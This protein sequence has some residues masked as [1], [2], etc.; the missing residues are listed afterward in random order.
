MPFGTAFRR[1]Q[2]DPD[3]PQLRHREEAVQAKTA[4]SSA[5]PAPSKAWPARGPTTPP[6]TATLIPLLTLGIPTQHHGHPAGAFQNYGIQP[7]R[8]CSTRPA[9]LVWALIASLYIGNVMLLVLNLPLVGPVGQAAED[10]AAAVCGIPIFCH[11]GRLWHAPERVRPGAAATRIG[12][13]GVL[14]RRFDF[15]TAPVVVGMIL[16]PLAEGADATRCRSARAASWCSAAARCRSAAG[17]HRAGAGVAAPAQN[18]AWKAR[19][20]ANCLGR[21][22]ARVNIRAWNRTTPCRATPRTF[23]RWRRSMFQLFSSVSGH[24]LVNPRRPHCLW[25]IEATKALSAR[26]GL[27]SVDQFVGPHGEDV[28]P[29]TQ[30]RRGT[31][32]V[33]AIPDRPADQQGRHFV[34]SRIRCATTKAAS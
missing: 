34:V 3:L 24:V 6:I 29:N 17:H 12:V 28:V 11:R 14:M 33:Q 16:G 21:A 27:S 15:L 31:E 30:M 32:T 9:A 25:I 22:G 10:P 20:A 13:L 8:S 26:P 1:R 23:W 4:R 2:R 18:A 5:P 19:L 7:G